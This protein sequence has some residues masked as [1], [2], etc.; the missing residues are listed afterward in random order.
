MLRRGW[1]TDAVLRRLACIQLGASCADGLLSGMLVV[2]LVEIRSF[3]V[4][5]SALLLTTAEICGM[6][7]SVG[8][9]WVSDVLGRRVTLVAA[10]ATAA[11]GAAL[12]AQ[13]GASHGQD[14]VFASMV[15][16]AVRARA[17]RRHE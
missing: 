10:Y 4:H 7:G 14:L 5:E 12:L 11:A 13:P 16:F 2:Y 9:G 8:L 6:A 17:T 1:P 3:G 15:A